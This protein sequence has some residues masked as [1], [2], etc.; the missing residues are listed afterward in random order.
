[1]LQEPLKMIINNELLIQVATMEEDYGKNYIS[2][3][4][5]RWGW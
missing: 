1:M 5:E 2:G 4:S 3:Q